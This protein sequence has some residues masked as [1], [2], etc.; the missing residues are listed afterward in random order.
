[1]DVHK[2]REALGYEQEGHVF[3]LQKS[4]VFFSIPFYDVLLSNQPPLL[5]LEASNNKKV[6]LLVSSSGFF[7]TDSAI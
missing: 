4:V 2:L 1:M 6:F 5:A 3:T 7:P